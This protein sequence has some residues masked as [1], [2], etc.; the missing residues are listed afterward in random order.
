MERPISPMEL[1]KFY[2]ANK[3]KAQESA[4]QDLEGRFVEILQ[5]NGTTI[6]GKLLSYAEDFEFCIIEI[7]GG[8][9]IL[10]RNPINIK[11]LRKGGAVAFKEYKN[12]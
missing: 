4:N 12:L 8:E 1:Y 6:S 7:E 10:C 3:G 2:L 9:S 5:S 11:F